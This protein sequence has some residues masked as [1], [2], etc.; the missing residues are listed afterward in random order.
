M[1]NKYYNILYAIGYVLSFM[2]MEFIYKLLHSSMDRIYTGATK[3][4]FKAFG[5]SVIQWHPYHLKGLDHITIGDNNIL[6][7]G[8]QLTAWLM[9][10][11]CP[12]IT[13][14]NNCRIRRDA[15]ITCAN[16][17]IIGDNLLT[18]TNVFITDNS[19]GE[20]LVESLRTSPGDRPIISKGPV[21]IGSNVWIGNNACILQ[22]V[23]IGDGAIIGANAVV[24]KDVPP[25][26]KVA[27]V[28]ARII[29]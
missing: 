23:T 16:K 5:N 29:Q 25:Y 28:P 13:I 26:A 7:K 14:G 1:K 15:H 9:G 12:N 20:T 2:P 8:L 10:N 27:G 4:R 19:H 17:I 11:N 22:N 21:I 6:E 18:G 3:R 24:T